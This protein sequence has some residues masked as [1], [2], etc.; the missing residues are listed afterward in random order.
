MA[1][2]RAKTAYFV[3]ADD[4]RVE[5]KAELQAQSVDGKVTSVAEVAKSL[6]NKW[7]DLGEEGQKPY[8]AK[9]AALAADSAQHTA[10]SQS[11]PQDEPAN[12]PEDA[13][14]PGL[15]VTSVKRIMCLDEDVIRVSGDCVKAMAKLTELFLE[16]FAAKAHTKAKLHKRATIKFSDTTQ[17]VISDKRFIE[18]GLKDMLLFDPSFEDARSDGKDAGVKKIPNVKAPAGQAITDFFKA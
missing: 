3:F 18:M 5:T 1:G 7:R 13:E 8:K 6:G 10:Q 9:A 2:K 11:E 12:K 4:K 16:L 14:V 17:A 15:P